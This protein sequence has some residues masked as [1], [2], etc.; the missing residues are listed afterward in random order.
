MTIGANLLDCDKLQKRYYIHY[1]TNNFKKTGHSV[2][3]LEYI[4]CIAAK[5]KEN[6]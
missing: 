3:G 1:W 6:N 2:E 4:D 5:G